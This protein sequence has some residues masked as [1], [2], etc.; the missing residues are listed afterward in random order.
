VL[1]SVNENHKINICQLKQ[2][3][4]VKKEALKTT[5]DFEKVNVAV[6]TSAAYFNP[7]SRILFLTH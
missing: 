2:A 1:F 5:S 4:N 6:N 7:S 3:R